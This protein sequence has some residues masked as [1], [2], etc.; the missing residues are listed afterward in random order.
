MKEWVPL[1]LAEEVDHSLARAPVTH[2]RHM[3][4]SGNGDGAA[5]QKCFRQRFGTAGGFII[6]PIHH[7]D[8]RLKMRQDLKRKMR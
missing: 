5:V 4:T 8:R 6:A 3:I 1:M 7:Q 2:S